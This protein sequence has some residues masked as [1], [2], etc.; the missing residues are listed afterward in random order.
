MGLSRLAGLAWAQSFPTEVA[1]V[2]VRVCVR[3]SLEL[4]VLLMVV[5]PA[6]A[7]TA[8]GAAAAPC[9]SSWS[10]ASVLLGRGPPANYHET[11]NANETSKTYMIGSTFD[12]DSPKWILGPS[13]PASS[14]RASD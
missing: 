11:N 10:M 13:L 2:F 4:P 1:C 3:L 7:G 12:A 8:A 9:S 5:P 6:P 14:F